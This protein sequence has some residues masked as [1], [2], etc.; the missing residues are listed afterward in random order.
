[1][2]AF[3]ALCAAAGSLIT[4]YVLKLFETRRERRDAG[5]IEVLRKQRMDRYDTVQEFIGQLAEL[6]HCIG[7]VIN[8]RASTLSSERGLRICAEMRELSRKRPVY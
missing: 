3:G 7:H 1:M 6:Y 5:L 4:G 8:D 2:V